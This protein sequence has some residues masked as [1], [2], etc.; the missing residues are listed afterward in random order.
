M[1]DFHVDLEATTNK[2]KKITIN[3]GDV[4]GFVATGTPSGKT[5]GG[6][7]VI[8]KEGDVP[9]KSAKYYVIDSNKRIISDSAGV[10]LVS[11]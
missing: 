10:V 8:L 5:L 11:A 2:V 3:P 7:V 4:L 6:N 9:T 1:V